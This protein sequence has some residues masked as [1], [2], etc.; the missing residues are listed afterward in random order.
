MSDEGNDWFK[1]MEIQILDELQTD[2]SDFEF[3]NKKSHRFWRLSLIENRSTAFFY[4][5]KWYYY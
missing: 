4:G 3:E 5:F 1:V 2:W